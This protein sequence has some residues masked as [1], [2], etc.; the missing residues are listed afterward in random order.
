MAGGSAVG[1]GAIVGGIDVGGTEVGGGCGVGVGAS[2]TISPST[3]KRITPKLHNTDVRFILSSCH[4]TN[5][6]ESSF[7]I[8]ALSLVYGSFSC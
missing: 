6:V 4:F 1:G 3:I 7:N 8:I 2:V 5:P